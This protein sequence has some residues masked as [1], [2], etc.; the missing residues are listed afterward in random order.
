LDLTAKNH[1]ND[2]IGNIASEVSWT[3]CATW[4]HL[5]ITYLLTYWYLLF[6]CRT[7]TKNDVNFDSVT[8][9]RNAT[10]FTCVVSDK[11]K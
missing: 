6:Y 8:E 2:A 9:L 10:C 7:R 11:E 3:Q 4:I 1:A 5:L